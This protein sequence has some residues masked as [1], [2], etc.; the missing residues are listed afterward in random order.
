[1]AT[2]SVLAGLRAAILAL[3]LLAAVP[4]A[5]NATITSVFNGTPSPVPC[6]TLANGVRLCDELANPRSTVSTFDG[7]PID[8]RVAFPRAPASGPD[9][10]YPLI[11][12]FHRFAGAKVPYQHMTYWLGHGYAVFTMTERGFGESCGTQAAR[13]AD[14]S[15]CANG[16]VRLMDTRYEVRD[17]QELTGML[18]DDGVVDP[19]RIAATGNSYGGAKSIALAA[20]KNRKMLPD[21]SLVPWTSPQGTPI[22]LA[23]ATSSS[24]WT[25]L[26]AAVVPNGSTLDYVED[27][28]YR[29]RTGVLKQSAENALYGA[30][31]PYNYAPPGGEPSGNITGW[32]A[33][34]NAGEP[35]DDASGNPL[36]AMSALR[37]ELTQYHSPYYLDDSEPPAPL[38]MTSGWTDDL[39]PADESIRFYNRH[40]TKHLGVPMSLFLGDLGHPRSQHKQPD[41]ALMGARQ[42]AWLDHYVK[43]EGSPPFQGVQMLTQTCPASAPSG[44]P[45]LADSWAAAAPGEIRFD[46]PSP[47][48]VS[49]GGGSPTVSQTF[50]PYA[51]LGACAT[52]PAA[53]LSGVATYRSQPSPA[54]GFTLLGSPTV[55]ADI[56][57]PGSNS[58]IAVRLLD[59]DPASDTEILVARA[60]WRPAITSQ[61]LTQVFQ[62]HPNGYRFAPGHVA[63]L[64]LLPK[65][66]P[67][68][69]LSN[70]QADVQV[71]NLQLRLPVL[72][73]PGALS[74][75]VQAAAPKVVPEGRALARDFLPPAYARPLGATPLVMALVPAYRPCVTPDLSHGP[76]L[77]HD[78]CA[79]PALVSP[80]LTVG[81]PDANGEFAHSVGIARFGAVRDDPETQPDEADV[82]INISAT[83]V[84][85][86]STLNDYTGE[87]Q[88]V[89]V[90]RITDRA[91]GAG[92]E[93]ATMLD[94]PLRVKLACAATAAGDRGG[95]CSVV[96]TVDALITG[97]LQDGM[98]SIWEFDAVE[99]HDGGRDSDADTPGDN[100][101]FLRQGLFVP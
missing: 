20:L 25:D 17:A 29:G 35:Y 87:L 96:T 14:P 101:L 40:R 26:L 32:H 30:G 45:Y 98:R 71:S 62:L 7:V 34:L 60:L 80:N 44:G 11:M 66:T 81:T 9:G 52:A 91:S 50:D 36:A 67:Y 28:G 99:V 43:G 54:E 22:S 46:F 86:A 69:R 42:Q 3:A 21:G 37:A 93:P 18:V 79:P 12:A 55:V 51:G 83:D 5:A 10:P 27:A 58:Q 19:G 8:V 82:R 72:E 97:A 77:S 13:Q 65:D 33:L 39:F 70:G 88:S 89:S 24:G 74:G 4:Q 1:M 53:D 56:T 61:P 2:R 85:R 84:R 31:L 41:N 38:M 15:G 47:A 78:A 94:T 63:K 23:A 75:L 57:S 90:L 95:T 76:P 49:P 6:S 68:G 73:A 100:R 16:F 48:T 59:V 64:E 92:A